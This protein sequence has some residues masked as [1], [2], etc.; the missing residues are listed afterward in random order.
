MTA[1]GPDI[2]VVG[3]CNK[4]LIVHSKQFP[5]PGET[6]LGD[7]FETAFGGKGANQAVAAGKS[8]LPLQAASTSENES[9]RRI[10]VGLLSCLGEDEVGAETRENLR[11]CNVSDE[12]VTT[13]TG[14]GV[15]SGVALITIAEDTNSIVVA[16]GANELLMPSDVPA[17]EN[18]QFWGGV[19]VLLC[20]LECG[21][22]ATMRALENGSALHSSTSST[23]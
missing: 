4:D 23:F 11:K 16:G 21:W 8:A 17:A 20:Q 19:K 22:P 10:R 12:L 6:V 5:R 7:K 18:E 1:P 9:D 14:S 2:L 3:N 15:A 13:A